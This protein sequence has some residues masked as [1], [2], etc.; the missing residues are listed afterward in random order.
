M[1]NGPDAVAVH[2]RQLGI[3]RIEI[4]RTLM[5]MQTALSGSLS[6]FKTPTPPDDETSQVN[7]D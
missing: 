7:D 1:I 6:D 5:V 3:E 4:L 2:L